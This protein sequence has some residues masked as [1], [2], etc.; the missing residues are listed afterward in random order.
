M[1]T[2]TNIP[3]SDELGFNNLYKEIIF[4]AGLVDICD[5]NGLI[6]CTKREMVEIFYKN[7]DNES[8]SFHY[9]RTDLTRKLMRLERKGILKRWQRS[10]TK[11]GKRNP[12]EGKSPKMQRMGLN[13]YYYID[14]LAIVKEYLELIPS[15]I[16]KTNILL[17]KLEK[18]KRSS[19]TN[20]SITEPVPKIKF[21]KKG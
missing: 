5:K 3:L 9:K 8:M 1:E 15:S 2:K 4:I 19:K 11:F 16:R 21:K 6:F 12:E 18:I 20:F 13:F 10:V 14:N 7:V 17:K